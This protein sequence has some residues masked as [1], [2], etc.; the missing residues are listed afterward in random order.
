MKTEKEWFPDFEGAELYECSNDPMETEL[1]VQLLLFS[2]ISILKPKLIIETGCYMGFTTAEMVSAVYDLPES[3]V[4]A[5]DI[6]EDRV[7][8]TR[9]LLTD[10]EDR[11]EVRHCRGDQLPELREC[12]FLYCDSGADDRAKEIQMAKV[13]CMVVAH[14][15]RRPVIKGA[16]SK[17]CYGYMFIPTPRGLA[18]GYRG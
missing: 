5:C 1:D 9:K 7:K 11:Y 4:I 14:D 18:F 3:H 12:D 17:Y 2:L 13:G 8:E 16:M 10:M 15:A 6:D